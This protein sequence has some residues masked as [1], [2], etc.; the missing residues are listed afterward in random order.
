MGG[1]GLGGK[2]RGSSGRGVVGRG[3]DRVSG[4]GGVGIDSL[5]SMWD[6]TDWG[7]ELSMTS[8]GVGGAKHAFQVGGLNLK[9]PPYELFH[10]N[11]L[12]LNCNIVFIF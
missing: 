5:G 7:D 10:T 8:V 4:V 3:E 9:V 2:N 11:R 1:K 12:N 6:T